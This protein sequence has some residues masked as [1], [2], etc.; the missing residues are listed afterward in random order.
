[1]VVGISVSGWA[2]FFWGDFWGVG[3]AHR[4]LFAFGIILGCWDGKVSAERGD[5]GGGVKSF[6][7]VA[8]FVGIIGGYLIKKVG[9]EDFAE[10]RGVVVEV[11]L[12]EGDNFID[13]G[14]VKI[15][16]VAYIHQI[17]MANL[18]VAVEAAGDAIVEFDKDIAE[19][20]AFD[21]LGD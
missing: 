7:L 10:S 4:Q 1:M 8:G 5:E 19:R 2:I 9:A 6:E 11:F 18:V 17:G 14:E 13:E 15:V 20:N 3:C 16:G 12:E 21:L